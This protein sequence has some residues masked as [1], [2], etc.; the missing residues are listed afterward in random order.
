L[1]ADIEIETLD[2]PVLLTV[3]A[4][5]RSGRKL[6]IRSRGL[7]AGKSDLF[8][9]VTIAVPTTLSA[10]ERELYLE[11]SR[12]SDFNPRKVAQGITT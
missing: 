10:R 5:S 3:P 8:A 7:V 11:L 6:R 9:L 1:G 4:G 2:G 12:I